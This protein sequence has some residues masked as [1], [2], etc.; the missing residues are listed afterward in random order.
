[1][2]FHGKSVKLN[3]VRPPGIERV[4]STHNGVYVHRDP[5]FFVTC[6]RCNAKGHSRLVT[7]VYWCHDERLTTFYCKLVGT[8][9][10]CASF[11]AVVE[12]M[13]IFRCCQLKDSTL[14]TDLIF[15]EKIDRIGFFYLPGESA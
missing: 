2:K 11:S 9:A 10:Q 13:G 7:W 14:K 15:I 4:C 8:A 1:M 3:H 5:V 12:I 6:P